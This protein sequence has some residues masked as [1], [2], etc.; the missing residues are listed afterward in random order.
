VCYVKALINL[1]IDLVLKSMDDIQGIVNKL[2]NEPKLNK[3]VNMG[4]RMINP[5]FLRFGGVGT[6]TLDCPLLSTAT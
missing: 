1:F 3:Y 2:S 5:I 6:L 4:K